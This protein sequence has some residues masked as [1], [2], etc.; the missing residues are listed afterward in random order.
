[1]KKT[2]LITVLILL[3]AICMASCSQG[4]LYNGIEYYMYSDDIGYGVTDITFLAGANVE[5]PAEH[6][7]YPVTHLSDIKGSMFYLPASY[8]TLIL[9]ETIEIIF[10]NFFYNA[11][12]SLQ[13]NEYDNGLYLGT[14]DN[15]YFAFIKVKDVEAAEPMSYQLVGE[16]EDPIK[17]GLPPPEYLE[18]PTDVTSCIIHPDTKIIANN[19]FAGCKK[20]KSITIPGS[21]KTIPAVAF[22]GCI[23]LSEIII[24]E[25]VEIIKG[26][27]FLDCQSLTVISLPGTVKECGT[28][29]QGLKELKT[30]SLPDNWT[31]IPKEMFKNCASLESIELNEGIVEIGD[32]AFEGCSSLTSI[33][34][35][36][37][38]KIIGSNAFGEC[39]ALESVDFS[40]GL[41][42]IGIAAFRACAALK[43]I[44]LPD[45]LRVIDGAA[46]TMC[47][48]LTS[49]YVPKN[50]EIIESTVIA[51]CPLIAEI[52]VDPENK[53]FCSENGALYSFDKDE[54]I[55]YASAYQLE[56]F[57]IPETVD[58]IFA[59]AFNG[60][61]L[62]EIII[63]D[64]VA[65]IC[66]L[67]FANMPNLKELILPDSVKTIDQR[68]IEGSSSLEK[69]VIGNGISKLEDIDLGKCHVREIYL[70][71]S[72]IAISDEVLKELA[73]L[74][75]I[76]VDEGNVSYKSVDGNLYSKSGKAFIKYAHGKS[77]RYFSIPEGVTEINTYAFSKIDSL[78]EVVIPDSV[79]IIR[80]YA[81]SNGFGDR[82][83]TSLVSVTIPEGV[84]QILDGA[85]FHCE[86]L[87]AV[88]IP[89]SVTLLDVRAFNS[90]F[91]L[92]SVKIGKGVKVIS[93]NCFQHCTSLTS[94][95]LGEN[96]EAIKSSSFS[97]CTQLTDI[98]IPRSLKT[99]ERKAFS[100]TMNFHYEGTKAEWRAI[101][102][103]FELFA[104][105]DVH[106]V[107]CSDGKMTILG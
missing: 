23:S 78:E 99:I 98:R 4:E 95:E 101:Q 68:I 71:S 34:L 24:E 83:P 37:S 55:A 105:V 16:A 58:M 44:E 61:S 86:N 64:G 74:E 32:S 70:P 31:S 41:T 92:E 43:N 12:S 54:L 82:T 25:G 20:L 49:F 97:G 72:L 40:N 103:N 11:P 8:K 88:I 22:G 53:L 21:I 5:I 77:E 79:K 42:H 2:S 102:K 57:T 38:L 14:K 17:E 91:S 7:G 93:G 85:F 39:S 104:K 69:L 13:Y 28:V 89:D 51:G 3:C 100:Q 60:S 47:E 67:A 87:K 50:V 45:S 106:Y 26:G 63:P 90:C 73:G 19:A 10:E 30:V 18:N 96:V 65:R 9:P 80:E 35:P 29:F 52:T 36:E 33:K 75:S 1:M 81:F 94:I 76:V 84:E 48:S 59:N 27:A 62:K 15:P 66:T 56:S 6:N 46:F 107:Y